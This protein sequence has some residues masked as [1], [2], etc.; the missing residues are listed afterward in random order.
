MSSTS[1]YPKGSS[2]RYTATI[3]RDKGWARLG[4]AGFEAVRMIAI[5]DDWSAV[6]FRRAEFIKTMKRDKEWAM[7]AAGKAKAGH[8]KS[9]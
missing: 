7:R 6:R 8:K 2:K 1:A 5:D 9:S 3:N 4:A